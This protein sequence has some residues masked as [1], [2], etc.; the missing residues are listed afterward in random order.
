MSLAPGQG[1]GQS[2]SAQSQSGPIGGVSF[3]P[4]IVAGPSNNAS[5]FTPTELMVFILAVIAA[6][7]IFYHAAKHSAA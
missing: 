3:G 4:Q 2:S 5:A 7:A 1:G 6:G